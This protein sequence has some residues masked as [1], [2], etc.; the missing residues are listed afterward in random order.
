MFTRI[1]HWIASCEYILG[2][3]SEHSRLRRILNGKYLQAESKAIPNL[4]SEKK[5]LILEVD[6]ILKKNGRI[7]REKN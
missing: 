4:Y 2:R 5:N 6:I 7:S 3:I 1:Q